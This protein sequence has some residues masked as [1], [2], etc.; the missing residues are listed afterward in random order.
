MDLVTVT[1]RAGGSG[2]TTLSANLAALWGQGQK[3]LL[4]DLDEQGDASSW[5]GVQDTGEA[6][7]DALMGRTS[8]E[9]AIRTSACGVDVAPAGEALAFVADRV[10]P[11]AVQRALATVRSHG[12]GRVVIDCAPSLRPIVLAAWRVAPA[13][14]AIV[15]VDSPKA[16]RGVA[17]LHHAWEDAGLDPALMR[18]VMVRHD[19][20]RVLDRA[21]DQQARELYG[22]AVVEARVRESVIVSESAAWHRPLVLHAPMHPV[23]DD[24]RRLAQEVGHG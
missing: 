4:I 24:L 1:N 6:L 9:A 22:A 5:L 8:L 12:Y 10:Q 17:R 2:K 15:P 11:D 7:A 20:R 16:L 23:T 19:G 13:V 18:L 14:R 3:T 21:L